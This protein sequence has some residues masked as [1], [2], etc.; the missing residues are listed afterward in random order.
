MSRIRANDLPASPGPSY[1]T[2]EGQR[3]NRPS[4]RQHALLPLGLCVLM[5]ACAGSQTSGG[6][7]DLAVAEKDAGLM[8]ACD[9]NGDSNLTV[10]EYNDC[11]EEYQ[12]NDR[13]SFD[14]MDRDGDGVATPEERQAFHRR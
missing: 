3:E 12:P 10:L 1:R 5:A 8:Q 9:S 7:D 13:P 6:N 4:M 2:R 14:A 11:R